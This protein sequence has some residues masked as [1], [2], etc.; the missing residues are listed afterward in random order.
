VVAVSAE[1]AVVGHYGLEV[2]AVLVV[3]EP[4][5]EM[6]G[7]GAGGFEEDVHS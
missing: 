4:G 3:E 6:A 2:Q 7:G 5:A 1:S